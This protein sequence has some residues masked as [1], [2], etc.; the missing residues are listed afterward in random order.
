MSA[1]LYNSLLHVDWFDRLQAA[2]FI[3]TE[4]SVLSLSLSLSLSLPLSL[5]SSL[6][7]FPFGQ[8]RDELY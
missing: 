7:M 2:Q 6:Q 1:M 8:K 4:T 3:T 5:S